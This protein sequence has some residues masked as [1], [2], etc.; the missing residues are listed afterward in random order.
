MGVMPDADPSPDLRERILKQVRQEPNNGDD[1]V[2]LMKMTPERLARLA[3]ATSCAVEV[4]PPILFKCRVPGDPH[5]AEL[6]RIPVYNW[7]LRP[8]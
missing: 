6:E 5:P 2:E 7:D 8:Q 3:G 4:Q 1:G